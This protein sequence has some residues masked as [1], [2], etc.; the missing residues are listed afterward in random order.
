MTTSVGP[1]SAPAPL[2]CPSLLTPSLSDADAEI[3]AAVFRALGDPARVKLLSLIAAA[4]AD[5]VCVCDLQASLTLSQPTVSH[6]LKLLFSA[7][8][9]SKRRRGTWIYYQ[10]RP[11]S[12]EAVASSFGPPVHSAAVGPKHTAK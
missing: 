9:V 5:G 8:L 3:A 6:H 7:G 10:L 11:E 1:S 12:L 4:P 2:C